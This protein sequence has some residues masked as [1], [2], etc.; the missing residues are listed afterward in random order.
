[1]NQERLAVPNEISIAKVSRRHSVDPLELASVG[2]ARPKS[3]A[4]SGRDFAM[5]GLALAF[6]AAV[7]LLYLLQSAEVTQLAYR[8]GD[9]RAE[10]ERLV[11]ANSVLKAEVL[12]LTR[13]DRIEARAEE[14]GL[15]VP[16]EVLYLRVGGDSA[17]ATPIDEA[18][19]E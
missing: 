10:L 19:T 1:M 16:G 14:L 2:Q 7:G 18:E 8:V 17:E 11:Q 3:P 5:V 13:L 15:E 6:V 9:R 4:L 12:E